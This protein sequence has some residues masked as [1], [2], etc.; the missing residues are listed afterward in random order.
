MYLPDLHSIMSGKPMEDLPTYL[1]THPA[2]PDRASL[3]DEL[4][5]TT[6]CHGRQHAFRPSGFVGILPH[7][8]NKV[9]HLEE[10]ERKILHGQDE[11]IM[12]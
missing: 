9:T 4:E 11:N 2:A 3:F 10:G 7:V 1:P 6:C 5:L 12:R 8:L